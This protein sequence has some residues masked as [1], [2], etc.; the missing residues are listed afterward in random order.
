MSDKKIKTQNFLSINWISNKYN[1]CCDFFTQYK[2]ES[3]LVI[4][5]T[6][7]YSL[8]PSSTE[9]IGCQ[10]MYD[11]FVKFC[12]K[13]GETPIRKLVLHNEL[14]KLNFKTDERVWYANVQ[15]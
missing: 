3:S 10:H 1:V 5:F 15:S 2:Q 8:V 12:K 4:R 6:K 11:I 7:R 13:E 9:I 14:R